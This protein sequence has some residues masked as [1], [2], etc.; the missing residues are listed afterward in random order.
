MEEWHG[1]VIDK[2]N[3]SDLFKKMAGLEE[4]LARIKQSNDR[5]EIYLGELDNQQEAI[6]VQAARMSMTAKSVKSKPKSSLHKKN[7]SKPIMSNQ[8]KPV[9]N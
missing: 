9:R 3:R 1:I 8:S 2:A 7:K 6:K 5:K 4:K